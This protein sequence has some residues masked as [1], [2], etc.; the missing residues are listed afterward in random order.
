M[1]VADPRTRTRTRAGGYRADLAALRAAQ[2][3]ATGTAAYSRHV[4]RPAGRRVAAAV[5][6]VGMTPNM[7]TVASAALS[8]AGL[9]VLALAEPTWYVGV[10]VAVLLAA[11]YVMDSVDGQLAR[12]S[13]RGTVS[14]E[15]L[16]HTV[17]TV[18]TS[19]LHLAVLVSFYRYPPA[20]GDWVLVLPLAFQVVAMVEFF[21]QMSMPAL[22]AR[23]PGRRVERAPGAEHPW[24]RWLLLPDDY[25]AQ[26]WAFVLLGWGTGFLA[27]YTALLLAEAVL[28]AGALTRWWRE[29][30][31]I[32][33]ASRAAP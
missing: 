30:R 29:L 24:R 14:G 31:R 17:D 23:S 7:A 20:E 8:A 6:Q 26:C 18:K 27:L 5:H 25:G 19:V 16:D 28:V 3:P 4:N 33:E 12:L 15:W 32:D 10:A 2:K 9:A 1:V 22:R 13:G 21:G 11:G